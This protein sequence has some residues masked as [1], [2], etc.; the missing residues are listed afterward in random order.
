M[1]RIVLSFVLGWATLGCQCRTNEDSAAD[2]LKTA[3]ASV[4]RDEF[5]P[6]HHVVAVDLSRQPLPA[7]RLGPLREM[8]GLQRLSLSESD[9]A[10]EDLEN[11][12]WLACLEQLDL[13]HTKI[14]DAGMKH[15]GKL[16]KLTML[17]LAQNDLSDQGLR[18]LTGLERLEFL[19]LD[20]TKVKR[21][22]SG[23][24]RT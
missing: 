17:E 6:S 19:S 8:T 7:G 16:D 20:H 18:E 24:G 2:A 4:S 3:G 15:V 22:G 14:T 9:T 12:E 21:R 23:N 5:H 11:L 13:N 10:D 1:K